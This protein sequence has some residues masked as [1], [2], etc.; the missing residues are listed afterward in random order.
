MIDV[1]MVLGPYRLLRPI[2]RGGM[3]QVFAAVHERMGQEVALKLLTPE[4]AEDSQLVARFIQEARALAQ[5]E[6]PGIV[7]V[8]QCDRL[9][10]GRVYVAMERLDGISLRDFLR[11]HGR[12]PPFPAAMAIARQ[13]AI[14]MVE[15]HRK[16]I[17]H[18]DLKPENVF[19]C[20]DE[21]VEQ[22][23]RAKILDFGIAKVPPKADGAVVDT[24]VQTNAPVFLGTATY[25]SPEQC[26][27]PGEVDGRADVYALGVLLFELCAGRPPFVAEEP[28][29]LVT[30][31]IRDE[32]PPLRDL[33]PGV[34][35]RLAV[36][37]ASMLSKDPADRP[38]ME[39]CRDM[40]GHA[41]E[42]DTDECPLPGLSPF[43]EAQTELFFGREVAIRDLLGLIEQACEG[44]RRWVQ[45]EGP[46]G[47][48]KS[49]LIQAG[50][51][52]RLNGSA[53]RGSPV[54]LVV[55][56]RPSSDPLRSLASALAAAFDEADLMGG[57][58]RLEASLRK[59]HG[60]LLEMAKTRTPP[61]CHLLLVIEQL[62]ELFTI[63]LAD[64]GLVDELLSAAL[65]APDS[66]LRLLTTLRSDFFHGLEHAEKLTTML[67]QTARY[68][69]GPMHEGALAQVI[70]GMARRSGLRL[71]EGLPERMVR[72]ARSAGGSLPLL[73]HALRGLWS[74]RSG[75]VLSHERYDD[76]GGVSGALAR[77]ADRL[78]DS[79][80]RDGRERAKWL[81]LDLVQ[82]GRGV[83]ATRRPRARPEALAA[84]GGDAMAAEVFLRLSGG[85]TSDASEEAEGLRLIVVSG[86]P[87]PERQ[88]IDLIH[89]TL[90]R[91][92]PTIA[93]WI[94][95]E[96]VLL[97]RRADLEALAR[98]WEEAGSPA[99]GLP[100]GTLLA[101][102]GAATGPKHMVGERAARFLG[103]AARLARQRKRIFALVSAILIVAVL[104][105]GVSAAIARR[106]RARAEE[107]LLRIVSATD[108]IVDDADWK[109]GRILYTFDVRHGVIAKSDERMISLPPSD[110]E[111]PEVRKAII[112]ARHRLSDLAWINGTLAE[113]DT[114]LADAH[115]RIE[116]G[117][118]SSPSDANLSM[119]LALNASKRG[120]VAMA[121]GRWQ[122]AE[123]LFA[124]ALEQL[125]RTPET[126]DV[127]D[128]R[129]TTATSFAEQA[130]LVIAQGRAS[131]AGPFYDKAIALLGQNHGDYDRGELALALCG[132]G[133][134]ARRAGDLAAAG[135]HLTRARQLQEPALKKDPGNA[136]A[137]WI[138]ARVLVELAA[139]RA[140]EGSS[141]A[142]AEHHHAA[143][144]L[145]RALH[146]GE[147]TNKRY[148]LVLAWSLAG[149]EALARSQGA[150]THAELLRA[151]RCELARP[152]TARDPQ[153]VR[154]EPLTC[155]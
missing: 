84:A 136:Y 134:A 150:S 79:L 22:G 69:L 13:L 131:A 56:L 112:H 61:G 130:D 152:F 75:T 10:D 119:L 85:R 16:G 140:L 31:H 29:D 38:T 51:L 101:Y 133:E 7:R 102:Y 44:E 108:E 82:V 25:M 146:G 111:I 113:A 53:S 104:S 149:E 17:V 117:L 107:N 26:R 2:G 129:R 33:A 99:K 76:L 89:E 124:R 60:A 42:S 100:S 139:L 64:C 40:L 95:R 3:G 55:S 19:L 141:E 68:H 153:D 35:A 70:Q 62:E 148:A 143:Q 37:V 41:W 49:S 120:K 50:L 45:I 154:F 1:G 34:P 24:Q 15:V 122:D 137:R 96:R 128:V 126:G 145:A 20:P 118:L 23:Y 66:P 54:W 116:R 132:R 105:V 142:A 71:A 83:P 93:S 90:L 77:H 125:E 109:L 39:R 147:P 86:G 114:L 123:T 67:N 106:E 91:E 47:A 80:G 5:L 4:S 92:V 12:R 48:G 121:S 11:Q 6:H 103:A 87:E 43:S 78:I 21:S 115:E 151:E 9:D 81:L 138:L 63:G 135:E 36:L 73:G 59:G 52:P 14:A 28:I 58:A 46:S 144:E 8:F 88:Q 110:Q 27:S 18:R 98:T 72:D 74:L 32:P 94:E 97:E 127:E 65:L 57:A 30:M 155:P